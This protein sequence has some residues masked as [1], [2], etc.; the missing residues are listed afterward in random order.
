[1][2]INY[3]ISASLITLGV[4]VSK[5]TEQYKVLFYK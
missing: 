5:N 1:M 3:N 4:K 2:Y